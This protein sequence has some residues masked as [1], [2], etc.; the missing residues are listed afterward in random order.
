MPRSSVPPD[1]RRLAA[2]TEADLVTSVLDGNQQAAAEIVRR[3]ERPVFNLVLRMVRDHATSEDLSQDTFVKVFRRLGTFDRRLRL[4]AW[5]LKVAHNTTIDHLRRRAPELLPLDAPI[6]PEGP[7]FAD[8]LADRAAVL[9]DR[10]AERAS[11]STALDAALARLRPEYRV[12]LVLRH[13]E[14][15]DYDEIAAVL[16][17][18]LG[19]VKTFLHRGRQALARELRAAGWD[20]TPQ[21]PR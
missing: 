11:L 17:V 2:A 1:D 15:L 21:M 3:F 6:D 19:T 12:T 4:A 20:P 18:P 14:D 9:P 16:G 8:Q 10:A 13:Q 7:T 5:I